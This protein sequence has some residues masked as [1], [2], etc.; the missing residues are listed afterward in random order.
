MGFATNAVRGKQRKAPPPT[1]PMTAIEDNLSSI[2]RRIH[3][4]CERAG[5]APESVHL[6]AV[7]KNRPIEQTRILYD[8]GIRA[9]GESRVQE[10]RTKA[11]EFPNDCQWHIIGPLQTNKVKY[12]PGLV[13]WVHSVDR[14]ELV[15][16][17]ETQFAKR[18]GERVNVLIQV[19]IAG[20]EQKSGIDP[21]EAA[22]LVQLASEQPHLVV[23]GL[24][25]M[26][27]Y[28]ENIE[29]TR[30]VFRGLK[31]LAT[32]IERATGVSLPHLSMGM[33]GDFEVAIEEGATMVRIGTA[34]YE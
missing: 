2:Q 15:E 29:E 11:P 32:E 9:F 33:T 28:T 14:A 30:P 17:L 25:T 3:Q 4:A 8:Q 27:P 19:N 23:R 6:V 18:S 34:L 22:E 16:A 12:L 10:L 21:K 24:M 5:R 1:K 26:A 7:S 31:R 13:S 20:E